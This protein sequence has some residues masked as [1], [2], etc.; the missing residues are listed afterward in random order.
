M[1]KYAVSKKFEQLQSLI[2]FVIRFQKTYE[3]S[4][5]NTSNL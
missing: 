3:E 5:I 4:C 2:Y 1:F